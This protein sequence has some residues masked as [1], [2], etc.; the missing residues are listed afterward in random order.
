M[1]R[2][3]LL[4]SVGAVALAGTAVAADLP[5]RAP[6]PIYVPPVPIFTWTGIYV[7]GQ[8]GYA[9]GT[10]NTNI[11]DNFGDFISFST[12]NSGVIGGAHVGYNLQL[13]QF[14]IGLEGDVDGSS[15]SKTVSNTVLIDGRFLTPITA[16][17]N[18]S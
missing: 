13:S 3:I 7:G 15:L 1:L 8:I 10:S 9:W 16:T 14:V 6:P 17:G 5:T 12:N 18:L 2:R 4:A 11:G